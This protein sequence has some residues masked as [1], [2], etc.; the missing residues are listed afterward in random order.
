M[1]N[2]IEVILNARSGSHRTEET[3]LI[4]D[5]V[6]GES[7]RTFQVTVASGDAIER[8]AQEKAASDCEV[9]VAGGGD[10]T[11][12]SVAEAVLQA[13]KT[14]GVLPLGT[15]NYFARNLGIPLDL[16]AA[17][18]VILEGF[19]VRGPVFELDG[20]FVLTKFS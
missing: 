14:L 9:L 4:I 7:K 13:G 19:S 12:C 18:H 11:I 10:G 1:A 2:S 6:V 17:A 16:E 8:V 5:T 3:R 15:F 20:G